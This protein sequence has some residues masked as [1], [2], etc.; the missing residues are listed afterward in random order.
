MVRHIF[1]SNVGRS[2]PKR[3]MAALDLLQCQMSVLS[4]LPSSA[5]AVVPKSGSTTYL[6]NSV[7][8][9]QV[10]FVFDSRKSVAA[11]D[12]VQ[13]CVCPRL[14]FRIFRDERAEPLHYRR[15]LC[16]YN[17]TGRPFIRKQNTTTTEAT[18]QT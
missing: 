10:L 17:I 14:D 4:L 3:V 18:R 8:V 7:D 1:R 2:Q 9:R 11:D 6:D 13:F 5:Y 12:A 16:M 15:R